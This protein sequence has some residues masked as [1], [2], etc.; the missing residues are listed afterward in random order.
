MTDPTEHPSG[1]CTN[2][3]A[4]FELNVSYPVVTRQE[5]GGLAY[6]SFCDRGCK[7]EWVAADD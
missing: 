4:P 5:D 7:T 2:C 6:Y 1:S 3:G